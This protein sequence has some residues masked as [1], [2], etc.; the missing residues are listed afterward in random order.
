VLQLGVAAQPEL[1]R[2]TLRVQVEGLLDVVRLVQVA[3]EGLGAVDDLVVGVRGHA[4]LL[5]RTYVRTLAR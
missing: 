5:D 2:R 1:H 4:T 3:E